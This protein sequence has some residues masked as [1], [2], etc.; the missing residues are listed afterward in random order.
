MKTHP[1]AGK[2]LEVSM[3]VD[4]PK[5]VT[6]Y[7]TDLP[8]P[9]VA[10]QRVAFG[11][12]GHRGSAFAT[13]FNE[14]HVLAITQAICEYRRRCG[15]DGP[16]F[17][18]MDTHALSVPACASALEVLAANCVDVMLAEHDEYTPTPAI[19]HA[20]LTYNRGRDSRLADGIVITPSHNPPEDG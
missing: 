18:G 19:S 7:Y 9:S 4:V 20:I 8:D 6:A 12:S 16:L 1:M 2:P 17:L 15:M 3:L 10:G 13:S 11:T 5:L 14:R